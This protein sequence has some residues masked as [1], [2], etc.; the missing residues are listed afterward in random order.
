MVVGARDV[1]REKAV[2][3][4]LAGE[5]IFQHTAVE[6]TLTHPPAVVCR[7]RSWTTEGE[8]AKLC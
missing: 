7:L 2:I 3:F 5:Q 8:E 6:L 4:D 1:G